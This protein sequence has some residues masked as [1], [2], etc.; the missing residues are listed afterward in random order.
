MKSNLIPVDLAVAIALLPPDLSEEAFEKEVRSLIRR[1]V[2]R[3]NSQ[4]L[5]PV[6]EMFSTEVG[7][8]IRAVVLEN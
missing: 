7:D 6:V 8:M 1:H 5:R 2:P 4:N 3:R